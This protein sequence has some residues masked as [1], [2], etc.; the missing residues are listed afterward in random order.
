MF[1]AQEVNAISS[2]KRSSN[3]P[4]RETSITYANAHH[5]NR[6]LVIIERNKRLMA[7]MA[8]VLNLEHSERPI[9]YAEISAQFMNA[10]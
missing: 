5:D 7:W 4:H 10:T 6:E 1:L 9:F 3:S 2:T 8:N